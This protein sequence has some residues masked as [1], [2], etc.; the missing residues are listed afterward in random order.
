MI[1]TRREYLPSITHVGAQVVNRNGVAWKSSLLWLKGRAFIL[2]G[3]TWL[4]SW[5]AAFRSGDIY[6][7]AGRDH[8]EEFNGNFVDS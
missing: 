8:A 3:C 6:N 4:F 5:A 1:S 7:T 2:T